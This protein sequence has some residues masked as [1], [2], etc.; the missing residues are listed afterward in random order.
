MIPTVGFNMRKITKGNV[1]IKVREGDRGTW[2]VPARGGEG[3]NGLLEDWGKGAEDR[4]CRHRRG[5]EL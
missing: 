2:E 5:K 1:T 4:H 3:G